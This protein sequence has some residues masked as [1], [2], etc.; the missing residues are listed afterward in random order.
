MKEILKKIL[1]PIN[2]NYD[3]ILHLAVSFMLYTVA[4]KILPYAAFVAI[5]V[6]LVGL[7]WEHVRKWLYGTPVSNADM[8]ANFIGVVCGLL[9]SVL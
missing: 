6:L 2:K 3:K 8:L 5:L 4:F 9:V 1:E 7:A